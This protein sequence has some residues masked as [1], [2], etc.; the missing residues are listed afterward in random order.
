MSNITTEVV[1]PRGR[2]I[3]SFA[4]GGHFYEVFHGDTDEAGYGYVGYCDG[5]RSI[6]ATRG[7]V[8]IN[9]LVKKHEVK[10]LRSAQII[11]FTAERIKRLRAED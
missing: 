5:E 3:H 6:S 10:Q 11:D 4:Q 1:D 8:A 9:A 7:D 2:L